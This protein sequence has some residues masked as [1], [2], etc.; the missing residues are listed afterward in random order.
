MNEALGNVG[1]TVIYTDT[2]EAAP[3]DQVQSLRDLVGDMNAGLVDLLVIVGGNPAYTAPA[4]LKFADAMAKVNTRVHLSLYDDETS[5]LCHWQIPE[6]HFLEAWSDGRAYDGTVS[7][8]Q[9]LIAPLYGGKSAHELLAA[10]SDRPERPGYDIVREHWQRQR[11]G[12][13][14]RERRREPDPAGKPG[15]RPGVAPLAARRRGAGHRLAG[16]AGDGACRG[17]GPAQAGRDR[18]S[19]GERRRGVLPKRPLDSRRPLRQQ[20]LAA[21]AAEADHAG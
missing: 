1:R 13:Q 4:D 20:R 14:P 5:A 6:A 19:S 21:G 12:G 17:A 7:I 3:I 18:F 10:M 2:V 9:P 8:V 15:I 16:K 11:S